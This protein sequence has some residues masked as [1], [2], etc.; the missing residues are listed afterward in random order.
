MIHSDLSN[1]AV[2]ESGY[3]G[4]E[5][6]SSKPKH[7][8]FSIKRIGDVGGGAEKVLAEVVNGLVGRGY[9]ITVICGDKPGSAPYYPLLSDIKIIYLNTGN[10]MGF[11]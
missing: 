10:V 5:A 6:V 2:Q 1:T 8:A 3:L 4:S 7:I 11:A 9:R